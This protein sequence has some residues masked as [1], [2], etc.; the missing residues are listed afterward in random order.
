MI[1]CTALIPILT[2]KTENAT[3]IRI[4]KLIDILVYCEIYKKLDINWII[5]NSISFIECISNNS[6]SSIFGCVECSLW[7]LPAIVPTGAQLESVFIVWT[8]FATFFQIICSAQSFFSDPIVQ[9]ISNIASDWVH[10][11]A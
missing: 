3:E 6:S 7:H 5:K 9:P 11:T 1:I 2:D 8:L 10:N 4:K